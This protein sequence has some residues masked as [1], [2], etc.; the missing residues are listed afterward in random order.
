MRTPPP[1]LATSALADALA[2]GWQLSISSLRHTPV[3]FGSHHWIASTAHGGRWFV[4]ADAATQGSSGAE[5][6][7]AALSSAERLRRAGGLGFVAAPLP[8][9]SGDLLVPAG[10]YQV[11]VYPFLEAQSPAV[12]SF[13]EP[14]GMLAQ[15][16]AATDVVADIAPV[17]DL[18]IDHR[19]AVEHLLR[20]P[21]SAAA[22]GPYGAAM[23][24]LIAD[25]RDQLR[26]A[27]ARH[28]V[29]AATLRIDR[30]GWVITHGEPKPDNIMITDDGPMLIDWDTARIAPAARDLWMIGSAAEYQDLTGRQIGADQLDFYRHRWDLTDLAEFAGWFVRPHQATPDTEIGWRAC[31]DICNRLGR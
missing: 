18:A 15:V 9:P 6:L 10:D 1:D 7:R 8:T 29:R 2:T 21:D 31:V 4:T 27:L 11:A 5:V 19:H 26:A 12:P 3:G 13:A 30:S 24:N 14:A 17:D 23:V 20:Y 25:H 16:H 28:D 22:P